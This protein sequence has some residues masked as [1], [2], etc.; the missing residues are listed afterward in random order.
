MPLKKIYTKKLRV[1][2]KNDKMVIGCARACPISHE[3]CPKIARFC[4]KSLFFKFFVRLTPK[5]T[6]IVKITFLGQILHFFPLYGWCL[7]L[8]PSTQVVVTGG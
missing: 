2:M 3:I 1:S 5:H 4:P 8:S 7:P 6:F